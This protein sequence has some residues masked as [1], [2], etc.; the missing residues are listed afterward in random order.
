MKTN[1]VCFILIIL[2]FIAGCSNQGKNNTESEGGKETE[3]SASADTGY[4]GIL[5]S[6]SGNHLV[7]EVT[8]KNGVRNGLMKTYYA[9]GL[10][11][12]TFWYENGLRQDTGKW[13]FEK[14][15]GK[16]FRTTPFKNDSAHGIQTQY[17]ENGTVRARLNFVNGLRTPYLEEFST[18]GKK[19][20]DYPDVVVTTTDNYNQNGTYK[21]NLKLTNDKTKVTFYRGEYIDGLYDPNKYQKINISETA[22]YLELQKS[23]EPGNNYVGI[24]AEI[25]TPKGNKHLVYKRIDLPYNNL[26]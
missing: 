7:K 16:V 3:T 19:V 14:I 10:L 17:Y 6:Y 22:G 20:T 1:S 4:T 26:K 2:L 5:Q 18:D 8:L 24:I 9:S 13:Y 12:Q 15:D 25:L 21:I 23:G 11:Y